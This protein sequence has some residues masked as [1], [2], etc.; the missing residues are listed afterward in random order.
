MEEQT[1]NQ[2]QPEKQQPQDPD[3]NRSDLASIRSIIDV[4]A[5]RGAFKAPELEAVG[6]TYNK[7]NAFLESVSKKD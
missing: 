7:L 4:A 3:L 6:K 1:Q 5:S 2:S